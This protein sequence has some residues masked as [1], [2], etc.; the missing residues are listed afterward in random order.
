M[1]LLGL[2]LPG[3]VLLVSSWSVAL[4]AKGLRRR[5]PATRPTWQFLAGHFGIG[6]S[7]SVPFP[8]FGDLAWAIAPAYLLFRLRRTPQVNLLNAEPGRRIARGR[9][10]WGIATLFVLTGLLLPWVVGLV[11]KL[12]LDS[13]GLPTLPVSGFLDPVTVPIL[14]VLT[15]GAWAFPFV[16]L[17]SAFIVPWRI[18]FSSDPEKRDSALPIWLAFWAGVIASVPTFVGVFWKFDAMMLLVP[19]GLALLPPMSVGYLLGWWVL[20]RGRPDQTFSPSD[21]VDKHP[22]T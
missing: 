21:R 18:G 3:V 4:L 7:L 17:A 22:V 13:K 5:E 15:L 6:L 8:M 19:V 20:H 2:V 9:Q 10:P 11:V 16:I 1:F 14:L 12:Y